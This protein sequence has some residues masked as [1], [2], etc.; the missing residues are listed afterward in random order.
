MYNFYLQKTSG[1]VMKLSTLIFGITVLSCSTL[2]GNSFYTELT[3]RDTITQPEEVF[4][5]QSGAADAD[6]DLYDQLGFMAFAEECEQLDLEGKV[7]SKQF[8]KLAN[9]Y[10]LNSRWQESEYWFAKGIGNSAK[11]EE[12]LNYAQVLQSNGKCEYANEMYDRYVT[13][14][15]DTH[16]D[17]NK[18]CDEKMFSKNE[19]VTVINMMEMNSRD[20][21]YCAFPQE[22]KLIFTSKRK[23]LNNKKITDLWTKTNF[24]DLYYAEKTS[25]GEFAKITPFSS[26]VNNKYHDGVAS[27]DNMNNMMY[28]SRSNPSYLDKNGTRRLQLYSAELMDNGDWKNVKAL[29]INNKENAYCH[30]SVSPDGGTLYFASDRPGGYGGMDIYM[31]TKMGSKWSMPINLGPVVNSSENEL[32]PLIT[33]SGHLY[34]GSNG[35]RGMGGLD[36]YRVTMIDEGK[37]STWT[38][39][40]NMGHE[41]NTRYDDF[42]FYINKEGT[43]GYLTSNRPGGKGKDDIYRWESDEEVAIDDAPL[44]VEVCVHDAVTGE[45]LEN[46]TVAMIM[47]AKPNKNILANGFI[48]A[49]DEKEWSEH[50]LHCTHKDCPHNHDEMEN[51][52][53]ISTGNQTFPADKA[54]MTDTDGQLTHAMDEGKNYTYVAELAGYETERTTWTKTEVMSMREN[55]GLSIPLRRKTCVML[56]GVVKNKKFKTKRIKQATVTL[57]SKCTGEVMEFM[58]DENGEFDVCVECGCEYWAKGEKEYFSED[59]TEVS[60]M[61]LDCKAGVE[62]ALELDLNLELEFEGM[63]KP[64]PALSVAPPPAPMYPPGWGNPNP[65][66]PRFTV[67]Q[68]LTLKDIY[69]DFDEYYIRGDASGDLDYLISLMNQYPSLEIAM[70]AHTDARGTVAYNE[71]LST[72]RANSAKQYVIK[73]GIDPRRIHSAIGMGETSIINQCKNG[74]KCSEIE[75]QEN[76]RTE[77]V[78]KR[79]DDPNTK[80]TKAY[81]PPKSSG[82]LM[83]AFNYESMDGD[84]MIR[85]IMNFYKH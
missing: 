43:E 38:D 65:N 54:F 77:I 50:V 39:R 68:V 4:D 34:F 41:Y 15:G 85:N 33:E 18:A 76:R 61:K 62:L 30:P 52:L 84:K 3:A 60:T 5:T 59:E 58:S 35:H 21:D 55:C 56:N 29:N 20:I 82:K 19:E 14:S 79:F 37:R 6:G 71:T 48:T 36:I 51:A 23:N 25:S 45:Q 53:A 28:F 12:F 26:K 16:I 64:K 32:F 2:Y 46:A 72:N 27:L 80:I 22:D 8:L 24:S 83:P 44:M 11:A 42:G 13:M 66:Q 9:S 73:R 69:Y 40:V 78:V 81:E 74:T 1:I 57:I 63:K 49:N 10:R 47:E 7:D 31:T 17:F 67:G 70:V 75:H